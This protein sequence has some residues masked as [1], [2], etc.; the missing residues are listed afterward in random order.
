MKK[1]VLSLIVALVMVLTM[2]PVMGL[3]TDTPPAVTITQVSFADGAVSLA[4][5]GQDGVDGYRVYRKTGTGKWTSILSSTTDTSYSD[6][7]VTEGKTYSYTV[8]SYVGSTWSTGYND[9]AVTI[10]AKAVE[11]RPVTITSISY[12]SGAVSLA[13][14]GQ[15]GVD[16]Y[17]VYR[18]TGTGKW[19]TVLSSTTDTSY[20]DATVTE[21]KKY[22]YTVR[23]YVGSTWSTGYNDT[24][25]TITAK[26]VEPLPVTITSISYANGAVNLAWQWQDGVDGYRVYRKAGT[27]K[28][29]S[30]LS[31]T[32]DTSYTDATVTE[33]KTYSYTVR[34]YVGSAWSTGYADTAVTITAKTAEPLPVTITSIDGENGEVSLAWQAQDGVDGYRV[35]RKTGTGKWTTVLS[36][37]TAT[38]YKDTTVT[39]GTTY[40]YTVRS[41][42]G[43]TYSTGY[44]D[45]AKS[46]KVS[47][48]APPA[49]VNIN[50]ITQSSTDGI[51]IAWD[52]RDNID[53][54]R[55]YRKSGSGGWKTV[56]ANTTDTTFTDPDVTPG[57]TYYYT[58]RAVKN[59]VWS[60]GYGDTA[61]SFRA[62]TPHLWIN[63]GYV[64]G[65]DAFYQD[66]YDGNGTDL[67]IP[68]SYEGIPVTCIS[69]FAFMG[70]DSL[71]SVTIPSSVTT[72]GEYAFAECSNLATVTIP[73][74][75]TSIGCN[76]FENCRALT[77]I[78]IPSSVTSI[79]TSVFADCDS[80][81]SIKVAA[82]NTAY[83]SVD[84]VL[85]T[86][87]MKTLLMYPGG[88]SG[89]YTV[90]S[91]VTS[92]AEGAFSCC[93]GITSVEIPE[94][95]TSIGSYAFYTCR[96]LTSATIP[97]T[98]ASI[99]ELAFAWCQSL[100]SINVDEGNTA[101]ASADGVLF[102]K[103]MKTL[104][105]CPGGKSGEYTVPTGVTAISDNAF[106]SCAGLTSVTIPSTVTNIGVF[107][108]AWCEGLTSVTIP[109]GVMIIDS[110][111]F[112]GCT[113]LTSVTLP[114][115]VMKLGSYV[116]YECTRLKSISIPSG[117]MNIGD[118]TFNGCTGLTSITMPA[119]VMSIDFSAFHGCSSLKDVY[120]AGTQS[121]WQSIR[122]DSYNDPLQNAAIHFD[123]AN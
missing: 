34:S 5:Q 111:A 100:T 73:E 31:S 72:I 94:G 66:F 24:A 76:A 7:T 115:S 48:A 64:Y 44:A 49:A 62:G 22:S 1:K 54:C 68:E 56:L 30:I 42:V 102:T 103:D 52:A 106:A 29:T 80:L 79:D 63:D 35:Y 97:S 4:W 114:S 105:T 9:T 92:I 89:A 53:G 112:N 43:S 121:R 88:K 96:N 37:T 19:T 99:G 78:T 2:L 108:F 91:G 50:M 20:S 23:S 36:S 60:T 65:F 87:D 82:G 45:T 84:G 101:Y 39:A 13:W 81:K 83:T 75:V 61:K 6:A 86:K 14:Q 113:G 11:P 118:F 47:P 93:D 40:S 122:I 21:G 95:V 110:G 27:G 98:A 46:V 71:T 57:V 58:V 26:A 32:T 117:I 70:E 18:K 85:Y 17:R 107:A 12:A 15:D 123:S 16:G 120:Y 51:T 116:F 59:G 41:K 28:W 77:S 8:R 10:T 33:G 55:V 104:I 109:E 25:V 90:L 3:A 67:V 38:S 69:G 119:S 74:G